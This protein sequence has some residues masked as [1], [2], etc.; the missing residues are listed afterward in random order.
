[1]P[2]FYFCPWWSLRD[3]CEI[4]CSH[5]FDIEVP[6]TPATSSSS[7]SSSSG[8]NQAQSGS[9]RLVLKP[10]KSTEADDVYLYSSF[11]WS[12]CMHRLR[13]L[14]DWF[15]YIY[16]TLYIAQNIIT[17]SRRFESNMSSDH[18]IGLVSFD[19]FM[20]FHGFIFIPPRAGDGLC[21]V[22]RGVWSPTGCPQ[23]CQGSQAQSEGSSSLATGLPGAKENILAHF[24]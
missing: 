19:F 14:L 21:D 15:L 16:V 22:G 12:R 5:V 13:N 23:L 4:C 18:W 7:S 1:M 17:I 10:N 8:V 6:W 3:T 20:R 2:I 9:G 11:V 24:F